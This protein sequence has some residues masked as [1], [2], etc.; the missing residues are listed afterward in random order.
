MWSV[1]MCSTDDDICDGIICSGCGKF[2][3]NPIG[4]PRKCKP[5]Q[6][7]QNRRDKSMAALKKV[8]CPTC[9][10]KVKPA[11]L[12]DHIRDKHNLI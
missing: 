5:C 1:A 3:G 12:A 10:K 2:L 6:N 9:K 7:E 4:Y 8:A 11:G